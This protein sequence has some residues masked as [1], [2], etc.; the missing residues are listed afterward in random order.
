MKSWSI[1][2]G[3]VVAL[4]VAACDKSQSE[5][6][7]VGDP[8]A[9]KVAGPGAPAYKTVDPAAAAPAEAKSD[10]IA[11]V[12]KPA[13]AFALKDLDGKE[14]KLSDYKGKTVVL[15]WYNPDCPFVVK[16]HNE[17]P[18]KTLAKDLAKN[19]VVYLA[20]NSGAPG[21][22]GA[23]LERNKASLTEY[24]LEHPVLLDE[25]GKVGKAY[26]ARNTP[27]MYV[28]DPTGTL[29]YAGAIDNAPMGKIPDSG[30]INHVA[31]AL[32]DLDAKRAV[33]VSETK[34]YGCSVKYAD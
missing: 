34:A 18:L 30:F 26:K 27:H 31:D 25:D 3:I 9:A 20:I 15:E 33:K 16:Q 2:F 5:A 11:E 21:K 1:P 4:G 23:G 10:A 13:P 29:A 17:G 7:K 22:Q 8:A 24:G 32:A 28:I 6:P 19:G 14:H 12:G